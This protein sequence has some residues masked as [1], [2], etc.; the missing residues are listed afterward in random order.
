M[1]GISPKSSSG[2]LHTVKGI[3][4]EGNKQ[5]KTKKKRKEKVVAVFF[6]LFETLENV[7]LLSFIF[8]F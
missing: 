4:C 8:F 1:K 2:C 6:F 5:N 7:I 3:L